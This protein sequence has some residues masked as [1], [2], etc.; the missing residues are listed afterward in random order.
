MDCNVGSAV[1][2]RQ[3]NVIIAVAAISNAVIIVN[4]QVVIAIASAQC[5][6]FTILISFKCI[7]TISADNF[8]KVTRRRVAS[9]RSN[10]V[11]T[12]NKRGC[13]NLR[14]SRRC[15]KIQNIIACFAVP[16][17]RTCRP[18]EGIITSATIDDIITACAG[19]AIVTDTGIYLFDV[20]KCLGVCDR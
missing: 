9:P 20:T 5:Q 18:I 15:A 12:A 3:G 8:N 6:N 17:I 13:I 1:V 16:F 7:V 10:T 11:K 4:G 19:Q 2:F 14:T